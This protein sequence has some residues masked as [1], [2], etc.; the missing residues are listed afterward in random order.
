MSAG[1]ACFEWYNFDAKCN[2]IDFVYR[3]GLIHTTFSWGGRRLCQG[4]SES[5]I[6]T[7][8]PSGQNF[9]VLV[10]DDDDDSDDDSNDDSSIQ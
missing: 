9:M 2:M 1:A 4:H 3:K 8:S 5:M 7:S 10:R 6:Q